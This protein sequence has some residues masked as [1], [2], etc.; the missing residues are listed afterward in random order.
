MSRHDTSQ[1]GG[2]VLVFVAA[3]LFLVLGAA[4]F[5]IDLSAVRVD[6][7]TDQRVADT[8]AAAG[9]LEVAEGRPVAGCQQALAYVAINMPGLGSL[10]SSGCASFS[11]PCSAATPRV[12]EQVKGRYTVRYVHPVVNSDPLMRPAALGSTNRVVAVDDGQACERVGVRIASVTD[13]AFAG[14]IGVDETGTSVHAVARAS[15]ASG[16]ATPINLLILDRFG[17]QALLV[18]GQAVVIVDAVPNPTTGILSAG[19]A[20]V[21]STGTTPA[22]TSSTGGVIAIEGNNAVLRADG[23]SGCP[24]QTGTHMQGTATVG[25]GCGL[26]QTPAAGTPG[27]A[28]GGANLPACTPGSGGANRPNPVPSAMVSRVTRAPVDHRYNCRSDYTTVPAS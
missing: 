17:C 18:R 2:F 19:L 21:D 23:P 14:V 28:G 16:S 10:D 15:R 9:A 6:R 26:I 24:T 5:A 11:S 1:E 25:Q 8:A 20:A 12:Y 27:C 4:A 7:A 22:C 3:A 13:T